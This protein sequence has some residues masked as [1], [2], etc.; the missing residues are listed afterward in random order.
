MRLPSRLKFL[1]QNRTPRYPIWQPGNPIHRL[2]F[3]HF[4]MRIMRPENIELPKDFVQF[5]CHIEMTKHDIKQ[6]LEKIYK[7]K[8]L[9]TRTYILNGK[10]DEQLLSLTKYCQPDMERKIALV[11]LLDD[12]FEFPLDL[13]KT[14]LS[15]SL[16]AADKRQKNVLIEEMNKSRLRPPNTG[17]WF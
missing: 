1:Y 4:W 8:V 6:Y 11:Q 7:V 15:K 5:E 10:P 2:F 14:H 12:E 3:P 13:L 16:D 17:S 9:D